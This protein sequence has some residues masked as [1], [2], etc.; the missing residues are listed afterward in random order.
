MTDPGQTAADD[1]ADHD[2]YQ[3]LRAEV[4]DLRARSRAHA[5]IAEAQGMLRERYALADADR[6]FTLMR[7]AS[8][9]F[10]VKMRTLVEILLSAPRPDAR[11]ALWF[12]RRA[13]LAQPAL[14][15]PAARDVGPGNRG[16]VLKAVLSQ[17]LAV[18]GTDMGNVQLADRV[19]GGLR[20]EAHTG[21][22]DDFVD[23]FSHVGE[24]GTACAQAARDVAQVTVHDVETDPVFTTS[25]R[26]A[27]LAAGS[28]SCHSVPLSTSSGICVGMVSAHLDHTIG[29]LT[30]AQLKVLEVV[31]AQA[32]RWIAWHER[33]VVLDA[34]E[35]LHALGNGS[36]QP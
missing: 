16:A 11:E 15:F 17:T 4:R 32:G 5:L 10:N 12:P 27:I 25:A 26:E 33:T 24:H 31:G 30:A 29:D 1:G 22:T 21:H 19:R 2:E 3:R 23:F 14:S 34:L 9:R 6:A 28:R 20:I 8:Q 18:V 13:R 36:A 7:L 35:Y